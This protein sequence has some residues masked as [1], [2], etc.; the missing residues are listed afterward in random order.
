VWS[1]ACVVRSSDDVEL[2][3]ADRANLGV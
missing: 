3:R 1:V 2:L